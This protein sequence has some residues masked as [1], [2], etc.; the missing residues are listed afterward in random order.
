MDATV[1]S[2]STMTALN[3]A[4]RGRF[5]AAGLA[6]HSDRATRTRATAMAAVLTR[7]GTACAIS[8]VAYCRDTAP[9][10]KLGDSPQRE[11]AHHDRSPPRP[12][13]ASLFEYVKAYYQRVRRHTS[14]EHVSG[15]GSPGG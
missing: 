2:R 12:G 13:E 15:Q 7:H 6:P 11:M 5:P 8:E 4:I 14:S 10:G 9:S 3:M 1:T